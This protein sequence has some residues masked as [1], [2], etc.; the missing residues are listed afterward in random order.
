[1]HIVNQNNLF[2]KPNT[3]HRPHSKHTAASRNPLDQ[4]P[5]QMVVDKRKTAH[6]HTM[7]DV[8]K[9][10]LDWQDEMRA[11]RDQRNRLILPADEAN[12]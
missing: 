9:Q 2:L 10:I 5:P 8:E 12:R 4:D 7:A 6:G 1:M 3:K 11:E